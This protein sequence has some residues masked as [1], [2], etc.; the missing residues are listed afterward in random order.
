MVKQAAM[1][2]GAW[3]LTAARSSPCLGASASSVWSSMSFPWRF[4]LDHYQQQQ[5]RCN[6]SKNLVNQDGAGLH[7]NMKST[8]SWRNKPLFRREGDVRFKTGK[9]AAEMLIEE[10]VR[11][12]GHEAEFIEAVSSSLKCLAVVFERSPKYA[13]I[14]KQL[15]EPE[16]LVHFRVPWIDDV[17]VQRTNRGFRVQH[18]SALG[19]Y[20]G[21]THFGR[22]VNSSFVKALGFYSVLSHSLS[23]TNSGAAVGGSDFM[24]FDKSEAEIQRFCQ[25]YMTE[26]S[27][28]IG[29]NVDFPTMGMGC[30]PAEIGYMFGQYKRINMEAGPSFLWGGTPAF[31]DATGYGI[32]HLADAILRDKGD[33]LEGERAGFYFF[34]FFIIIFFLLK[35]KGGL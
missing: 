33:T 4:Q 32:A 22:A 7:G 19:P 30:G 2:R 21:S 17:G 8:G 31:P 24:P 5:V 12:D 35:K 18:S 25:S 34:I 16:R 9:E 11:R 1:M 6:S 29:H 27:K 15:L 28:Y 14:A 10:A 13:W 26:L 3:S 20:L 23:G